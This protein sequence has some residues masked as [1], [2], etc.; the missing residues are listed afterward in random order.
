MYTTD[1]DGDKQRTRQ[2]ISAVSA[3]KIVESKRGM[4]RQRQ[5][6]VDS[7]D[8]GYGQS[9]CGQSKIRGV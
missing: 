2:K 9:T 8:Q 5:W 4:R 1:T 6:H 3:Q 7:A